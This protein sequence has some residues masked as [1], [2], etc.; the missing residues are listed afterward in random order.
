MAEA[1]I[2]H[3]ISATNEEEGTAHAVSWLPF[4]P[5]SVT[6][7]LRSLGTNHPPSSG[8]TL[9]TEDSSSSSPRRFRTPVSHCDGHSDKQNGSYLHIPDPPSVKDP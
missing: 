9:G 8:C 2:P 6:S 1:G 5:S 4:L 3:P 7:P